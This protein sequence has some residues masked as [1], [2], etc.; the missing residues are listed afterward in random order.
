MTLLPSK[1]VEESRP[2][3][4]ALKELIHRLDSGYLWRWGE[5]L[6][7]VPPTTLEIETTA[8]LIAA[9][10]LDCGFHPA[11]LA[12]WIEKRAGQE[13]KS[14]LEILRDGQKMKHEGVIDY[15]FLIA[16]TE[17]PE[18]A[19]AAFENDAI[20]VGE[21]QR[22]YST[23]TNSLN[24]GSIDPVK[25]AAKISTRARDPFSA[26]ENVLQWLKRYET[27]VRISSGEELTFDTRVIDVNAL[28]IR[29][30][31]VG[32]LLQLSS[33]EKHL[34]FRPNAPN[35]TV[36]AQ[37][38]DAL[39]LLAPH[40]QTT[41]GVSVASLWAAA[42]GLLGSSETSGASVATRLAEIVACSFPRDEIHTL[43]RKWRRNGNG[44]LHD[45][46]RRHWKSYFI[47]AAFVAGIA[48]NGDPGFDDA[49]D[50]AAVI[51]VQ[52]ALASPQIQVATIRDYLDSAFRRLYYQRNYIMH[53]AKFDSVS[54]VRATEM[55][56]VLVAAGLEQ[57]INA[58]TQGHWV[59]PGSLAARAR[60]EISLLGGPAAKPIFTLLSS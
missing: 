41:P 22:V 14:L 39:A 46:L 51:R 30:L 34:V 10:L 23:A 16:F 59:S 52:S 20:K 45:D 2:A 12:K 35:A 53:A 54:L 8:R 55:S 17:I 32:K 4:I 18:K 26:V 13:E 44:A 3:L 38:D 33:I 29:E 48:A 15:D 37:I 28:K 25:G 6:T 1:K 5:A 40:L 43:A 27:R 11:H 50:S 49:A 19:L 42:E 24:M 47:N 9:D 60:N 7:Q 57:I 31:P 36:L 56:P 21:F 58:Q